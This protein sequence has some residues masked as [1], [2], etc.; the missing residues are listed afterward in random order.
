MGDVPAGDLL[1]GFTCSPLPEGTPVLGGI[2]LLKAV[3]LTD[4]G[5]Y[6]A[7]RTLG[8]LSDAERIGL[9]TMERRRV[10]D[11]ATD[12]YGTGGDDADA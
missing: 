4:G 7:A 1:A 12:W 8:D 5:T 9:L 2:V 10:M 3:D 11:N 6:W